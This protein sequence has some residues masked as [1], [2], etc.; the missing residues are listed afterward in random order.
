MGLK[1]TGYTKTVYSKPRNC[2]VVLSFDGVGV[3]DDVVLD[4]K[5][6]GSLTTALLFHKV[7]R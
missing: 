4:K 6:F 3:F 7:Y 1:L 2:F 5:V